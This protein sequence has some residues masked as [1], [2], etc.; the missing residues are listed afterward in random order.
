[1]DEQCTRCGQPVDTSFRH[2]VLGS[3]VQ[4]ATIDDCL[5]R[6]S[7]RITELEGKTNGDT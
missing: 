5:W 6:M 1:M 4:H 7:Q 2:R 3:T